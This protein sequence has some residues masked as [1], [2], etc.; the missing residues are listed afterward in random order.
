MRLLSMFAAQPQWHFSHLQQLHS[1][2][3]QFAH[4]QQGQVFLSTLAVFIT[5]S[6]ITADCRES[7]AAP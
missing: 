6:W 7:K 2:Q 5:F 4:L 1:M 3:L